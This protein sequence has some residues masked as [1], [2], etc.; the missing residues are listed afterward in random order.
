VEELDCDALAL[1]VLRLQSDR[2]ADGEL[3]WHPW[4]ESPGA[5][6]HGLPGEVGPRSGW[7]EPFKHLP[8]N[9]RSP[10]FDAHIERLLFPTADK[11]GGRQLCCP[12]RLEIEI[13]RRP[14]EPRRQARVDLL[15]RLTTPLDPSSTFGLIHLSLLPTDEPDAPDALWWRWAVGSP[16]QKKGELSEMTLWQG[17]KRVGLEIRRPA[18]ALAEALFGDPHPRLERSLYTVVMARC[19]SPSDDQW[20]RE[21]AVPAKSHVFDELA[22]EREYRQTVSLSSTPGLLLGRSA[23][24]TTDSITASRARNLRSYWGESIVLG[25]MQQDGLEEFQRRLADVGDLLDPYVKVLRGDW[26]KFRNVLWWSRLSGSEIPQELVSRL[27]RELGTESL[28]GELE[29][30]LAVYSEHQHQVSEDRQ[31]KALANLQIYG[32]A[33]VVLGPLLTAIGLFG[34]TD[35]KRAILVGASLLVAICVM[36]LVRVLLRRSSDPP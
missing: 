19:A 12:D 5:E 21:L 8:G 1:L 29:S 33:L 2:P 7:D 31:T 17:D 26:L 35:E 14:G 3:S 11:D 32:S 4:N 36:Q 10:Y 22:E 16:F 13:G 6:Q 28:F 24:F 15:E 18:R 30:D 34:W 27:R 20:R 9:D 25:L 23:V